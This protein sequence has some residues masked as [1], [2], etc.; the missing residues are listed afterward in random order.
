[1]P[2]DFALDGYE[3]IKP[4]SYVRVDASS[5]VI[6]GK[7]YKYPKKV[8]DEYVPIMT[9]DWEQYK[10]EQC[11]SDLKDAG[12][13]LLYFEQ[14]VLKDKDNKPVTTSRGSSGSGLMSNGKGDAGKAKPTT[15]KPTK[16]NASK[17]GKKRKR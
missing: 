1:M 2:E 14:I 9:V 5:V 13:F 16:G 3:D 12:D 8:L 10:E 17:A 7:D 4:F 11:V 6:F 15:Q